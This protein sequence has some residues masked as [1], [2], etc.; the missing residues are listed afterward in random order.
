MAAYTV[1]LHIQV[2]NVST[3]S[4][5]V[6]GFVMIR[7]SAWLWS[8]EEG[9]EHEA[10]HQE[11]RG[12]HQI[13]KGVWINVYHCLYY[14]IGFL[15]LSFSLTLLLKTK[16]LAHLFFDRKITNTCWCKNLWGHALTCPHL[17]LSFTTYNLEYYSA[18]FSVC[19]LLSCIPTYLLDGNFRVF[20]SIRG[21]TNT[22]I[23]CALTL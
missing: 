4:L 11:P 7:Y 16:T 5:Q 18:A 12:G 17:P 9:A 3:D 6:L 22:A 19:C 2:R 8:P 15:F 23:W 21:S 14:I 13:P 10:Y 1:Q 20:A